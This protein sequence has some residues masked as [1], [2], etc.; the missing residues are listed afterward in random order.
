MPLNAERVQ[1]V[2]GLASEAELAGEDVDDVVGAGDPRLGEV[3]DAVA[4]FARVP[5]RLG[6]LLDRSCVA[7]ERA[8]GE[9]GEQVAGHRDVEARG[10]ERLHRVDVALLVVPEQVGVELGRPGDATFQ[11]RQAQLGESPRHSSH[12]Q[13]AADRLL[14]GGEVAEVVVDVVLRRHPAPPPVADA[15]ERRHHA[16]LDAARPQRVVVVEAVVAERVDPRR[17]RA[18]GSNRARHRPAHHHRLEPEGADG[19]VELGHRLVRAERRDHGDG[20][21]PVAVLGEDSGV[22]RVQRACR[23]LA[24]LVVRVAQHREPRGRVEQREVEADLFQ[25]LVE[26]LRQ[27]HGHA[28]ERGRAAVE[29]PRRQIALARRERRAAEPDE[30]LGHRVVGDLTHAVDHHRHELGEVAVG[31]DH[32][33]RETAPYPRHLLAGHE[34]K[35]HAPFLYL[36]PR[37]ASAGS[38]RRAE[39]GDARGGVAADVGTRDRE[40]L[41]AVHRAH[42]LAAP[43]RHARAG[44]AGRTRCPRRAAGRTR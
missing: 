17:R 9:L 38:D 3:V 11:E 30:P 40:D 26:Q 2:V 7:T 10:V 36:L 29:H 4:R 42:H 20:L 44:G 6:A 8:F 31:V 5:Q 1:R 13:R 32:R 28:I 14:R 21:E 35:S 43:G 23:R 27:H 34:I 18:V 12:D 41:G 22:V 19:V 39:V 37:R 33:M 24:Q 16:E 25:T 15:V